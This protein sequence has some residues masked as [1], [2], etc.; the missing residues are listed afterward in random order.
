[1]F[2]F[3]HFYFLANIAHVVL[4][5]PSLVFIRSNIFKFDFLFALWKL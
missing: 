1:M 2:I 3:H 4:L 5:R